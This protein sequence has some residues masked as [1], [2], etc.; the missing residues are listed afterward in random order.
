MPFIN[1]L[2][3]C[4]HKCVHSSWWQQNSLL[5]PGWARSHPCLSIGKRSRTLSQMPQLTI[6]C[7]PGRAPHIHT[8]LSAGGPPSWWRKVYKDSLWSH[9]TSGAFRN[10]LAETY[11]RTRMFL[12]FSLND[13]NMKHMI[14]WH[15]LLCW[16]SY[17]TFYYILN[18]TITILGSM[19]L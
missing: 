12:L 16:S 4:S 8:H 13:I 14:K 15:M 18:K 6:N 9:K 7:C 11:K 10:W 3:C 19:P 5:P 1:W 2:H 17:M